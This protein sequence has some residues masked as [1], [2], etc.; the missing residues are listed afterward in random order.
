MHPIAILGL[1]AAAGAGLAIATRKRN[2]AAD[3]LATYWRRV[4]AGEDPEAVLTGMLGA[5]PDGSASIQLWARARWIV[6]RGHPGRRMNMD[7]PYTNPETGVTSADPHWGKDIVADR[8]VA[9]RAA[10]TGIVTHCENRI[11]GFGRM[12]WV[13]HL[14]RDNESTFY[15]HL[16]GFNVGLGQLVTGGEVIGFVGNT[17]HP[18]GRRDVPAWCAG[19]GAHLHFE[20][21]TS[22]IPNMQVR[23][24]IR[25]GQRECLEPEIWLRENGIQVVGEAT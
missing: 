7:D 14:E 1:V 11:E 13:S 9:V 6:D 10:K 19:M 20:V 15:A 16:D 24:N 25:L 17:C 4:G 8:G 18:A 21:H 2:A 22:R 5:P 3:W 23:D 12:I